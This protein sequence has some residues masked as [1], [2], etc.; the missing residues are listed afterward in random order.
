MRLDCSIPAVFAGLLFAGCADSS[1]AYTDEMPDDLPAGQSDTD[2]SSGGTPTTGAP[3]STT[4]GGSTT[5]EAAGCQSSDECLGND[6]CVATWDAETQTHGVPEC[7][8]SCIPSLDD[9]QWCADASA[10]CDPEAT[11]TAR[12]YCVPP[13]EPG[14]GDS[15]GGDSTG[16]DSTGSTGG[17]GTTTGTGGGE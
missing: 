13:Q 7:S 16:G 12:G 1:D 14:A 5:G 9:A 6:V 17:D 3:E 2:G 15:T 4:T 10:C 11:C 8:F